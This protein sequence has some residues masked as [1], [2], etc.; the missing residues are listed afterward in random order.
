MSRKKST[1]AKKCTLLSMKRLNC[2]Q[3]N[4]RENRDG[5]DFMHIL[6]KKERKL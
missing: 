3:Y 2:Y 4:P 1:L 6:M 5:H